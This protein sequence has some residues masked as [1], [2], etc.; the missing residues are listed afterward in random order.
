MF[1]LLNYFIQMKILLNNYD[2]NEALKHIPNLGFVPTMGSLHKGHISLIKK[3]KKKSSKTIVSIF[4][5]PKQ[6]NSRSDFKK[7]PKNTNKDLSLLKK[8]KV[9]FVYLPNKKQIYPSKRK[10]N[11]KLNKNNQIM[12]AKFRKGHFEGVINVMDRLTS[13]INPK[14]IFMGQKDMQQLYLVKKFIEKKYKTE[15]ISCKTVRDNKNLALSSRNNLLNYNQIKEARAFINDLFVFKKKLRNKK[16]LQILIKEKKI[17]LK[18]FFNIK[19]EYLEMRNLKNLKTSNKT[20]NSK[21]FVAYYINNIR[22]ID[23]V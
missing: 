16:K 5:N 1:Y 2:L 11:I 19:L 8:L 12:C 15:I 4:V 18:K 14:K 7:Y 21:L 20:K 9:D 22:L 6:F 10:F 3:S 23:N 13:L 17:E